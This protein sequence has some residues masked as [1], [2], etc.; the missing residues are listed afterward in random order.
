MDSKKDLARMI[1]RDF[2]SEPEALKAAKRW[3]LATLSVRNLRTQRE[4]KV[5]IPQDLEFVEIPLPDVIPVG[6]GGAGESGAATAGAFQAANSEP[7]NFDNAIEV[8]VNGSN[9][10]S[11]QA[12]EDETLGAFIIRQAQTHGVRT[13]TV[14]AD[15]HRIS[16]NGA[17]TA[18]PAGSVRQLEIIARDAR[19]G[20]AAVPVIGGIEQPAETELVRIDKLVRLAGLATSNTEAAGKQKQGAVSLV[21]MDGENIDMKREPVVMVP[22]N[23]DIVLRVGRKMKRIRVISDGEKWV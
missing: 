18:R 13:F 1:V 17:A 16:P 19:A 2:H 12:I 22:V 4:G 6:S 11:K 20:G 9:K 14:L 15:G 3:E 10:G 7:K 8:I 23:Q 21:R 5:E